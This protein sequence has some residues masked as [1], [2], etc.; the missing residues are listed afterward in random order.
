MS[1]IIIGVIAFL[2]IGLFHPIVVKCEY[3]F[4]SRC[5]PVF[6]IAGIICLIAS[7]GVEN[8]IGSAALGIL[9]MSCLWSIFELKEQEKR[10]AKGWFPKRETKSETERVS[11][12]DE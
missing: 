11:A 5:W 4:S 6:L 7:A 12:E 8:I 9:G 2:L 3:Y 10:V 1:G